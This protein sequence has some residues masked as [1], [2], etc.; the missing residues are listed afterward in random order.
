MKHLGERIKRKRE[1]LQM[2]LN[3]LAKKVGIS[4]SALSQ[5]EKAKAFPSVITLKSIADSLYTTVGE[6]I[7]ENEILTKNP[8]VKYNEKSFVEKN[9]SGASLF[10][11][12]NHG[13][14]KQMDTFL[15]EFE[16]GSD[17][18]GIMKKHPGQEF[19][20]VLNGKIEFI[21]EDRIFLLEKN[22][23]FYFNSAR[24]HS[25]RNISKKISQIVW[26]VT[27]PEN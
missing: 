8:L 10:L 18:V 4:A 5:I 22:D 3:E 20:F 24:S 26:V 13:N 7:G 2:K 6:L 12:S 14:G 16:P 19:C 17:A 11:L 25:V 1:S 15:I 27:P 9:Q 23:S 21:L